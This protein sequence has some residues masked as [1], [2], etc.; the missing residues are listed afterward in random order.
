VAWS[1]ALMTYT[2]TS[3]SFNSEDGS[4][5]ALSA[6]TERETTGFRSKFIS[7]FIPHLYG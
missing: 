1:G 4:K 2:R 5:T 7:V 6:V 3:R